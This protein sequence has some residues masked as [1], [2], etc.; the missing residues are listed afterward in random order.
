MASSYNYMPPPGQKNPSKYPISVGPNYNQYGEQ[1]GYVYHPWTDEYYIDPN[2]QNQ[3]YESQGLGPEKA[4]GMFE[5]LAPV[6]ATADRTS[7]VAVSIW[8][9]SRLPARYP[10]KD[11][12]GG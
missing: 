11:A 9:C 5:Q 6:A 10:E 2:A 8:E 1:P 7:S 3:Y 4:P 12:F